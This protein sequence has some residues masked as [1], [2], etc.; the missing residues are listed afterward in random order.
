MASDPFDLILLDLAVQGMHGG[1]MPGKD[2][3]NQPGRYR[4]GIA[5]GEGGKVRRVEPLPMHVSRC[6]VTMKGLF[7]KAG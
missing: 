3:A 5:G 6:G 1:R 4:D 7:Y 2:R